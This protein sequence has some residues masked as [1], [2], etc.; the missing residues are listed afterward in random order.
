[1]GQA[2]FT[3][4]NSYWKTEHPG[5]VH[6]LH[7]SPFSNNILLS[8]WN[9]KVHYRAH[10][11]TPLDTILNQPNPVRPIDP[12]LPKV[13]LNVIFPP[14]PRSSQWSV[15]FGPPNQK[16]LNTSPLPHA[17]HMS[18]PPHP[19]WFNHPNNIWWIIQAMKIIIMQF[20]LQSFFIP[21]RSKYPPHHFVLKNPQSMFLPQSERPSFAFIEQDRNFWTE[22]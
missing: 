20:S 14:T 15:P 6:L 2:H 21:F 8:L 12:Y 5:L 10:K 1:M 18:R 17:C 13:H 16:P 7:L 4:N 19:P 9:P 11:S 22:L 3:I